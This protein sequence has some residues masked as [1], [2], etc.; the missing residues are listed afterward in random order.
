M[1]RL[2]DVYAVEMQALDPARDEYLFTVRE[3]AT[4]KKELLDVVDR[5]SERTRRN[6]R[7]TGTDVSASHEKV[8]ATVTGSLEAHRHYFEGLRYLDA[9][10]VPEGIRALNAAIEVDPGFALA[11]LQLL[12]G[13]PRVY[14][15]P[16]AQRALVDALVLQLDRLPEGDRL[17]VRAEEAFLD[18]R[19]DE[20]FA[21]YARAEAGSPDDKRILAREGYAQLYLRTDP[22]AAVRLAERALAL[23]PGWGVA[24]DLMAV[25]LVTRGD[26]EQALLLAREWS[27]RWPSAL[28]VSVVQVRSSTWAMLR[29]PWPRRGAAT[30]CRTPPIPPAGR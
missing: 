16:S 30:R 21:L 14:R 19:I 22:D 29:G 6:F 23:D 8:A 18:G 5:L 4:A 7:E 3:Q 25:S 15:S 27:E 12:V 17:V 26:D 1:Q 13:L 11:R 24:Q 2:D 10:K 9:Y 20:G 28:A